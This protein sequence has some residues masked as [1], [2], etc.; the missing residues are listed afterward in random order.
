M[1]WLDTFDEWSD[2]FWGSQAPG[3]QAVKDLVAVRGYGAWYQRDAWETV[4][5]W[6][7]R[8]CIDRDLWDYLDE[9]YPSVITEGA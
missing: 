2:W 3:E 9:R 5:T 1:A 8:C 6:R 4:S 7:W